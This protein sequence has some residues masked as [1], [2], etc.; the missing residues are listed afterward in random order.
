MLL[1]SSETMLSLHFF[2]SVY[3]EFVQTRRYTK[4]TIIYEYKCHELPYIN[5]N[6]IM[7]VVQSQ[8][9]IDL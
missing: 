1:V 4:C 5:E 3:T 9:G 2:P 6:L 7:K 8:Q